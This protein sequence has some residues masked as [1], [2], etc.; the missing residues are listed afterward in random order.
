MWFYDSQ[1]QSVGSKRVLQSELS[2]ITGISHHILLH[3]A[4]LSS[5]LIAQRMSW[6]A[7]RETTRVEDE[8]YCL[9]GIFDVNMPLLYGEESKAFRRLQEEIIKSSTDLSI[10]AWTISPLPADNMGHGQEYYCGILADSP[11]LFKSAGPLLSSTFD[12][13]Q[14]EF[15]VTNKGLKTGSI[16]VYRPLR[17]SSLTYLLTLSCESLGGLELGVQLQ[18]ISQN[19]YVRSNPFGL[20]F[21][22]D[23]E[24]HSVTGDCHVLIGNPTAATTTLGSPERL[25]TSISIDS[26]RGRALQIKLPSDL[27]IQQHWGCFDMEHSQFLAHQGGTTDCAGM[28]FTFL[29]SNYSEASQSRMNQP[30]YPKKVECV[31]YAVGWTGAPE[32]FQYTIIDRYDYMDAVH[33]IEAAFTQWTDRRNFT[34][35]LIRS[36]I[37]KSNAVVI[38]LPGLEGHRAYVHLVA[39]EY[40][41]LKLRVQYDIMKAENVPFVKEDYL[42]RF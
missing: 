11:A 18:M 38:K 32:R 27:T 35:M 23:Q 42:W 39:P 25:W 8:A 16:A 9:L 26:L 31:V 6:A 33:K 34:S 17:E 3:E 21:Y 10:F 1:W 5:I 20:C 29:E 28:S 15:S 2:R 22:N 19:T 30:R 13:R 14:K 24:V 41:L 36:G 7:G 37:P 40:P 12:Q 4:P